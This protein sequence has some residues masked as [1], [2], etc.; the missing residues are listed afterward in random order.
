MLS[1]GASA[2]AAKLRPEVTAAELARKL[3]VTPQAVSGWIKG[4][5]VP[6]PE[7]LSKLEDV[8]GIPMRAWT[9]PVEK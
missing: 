3:G 7:M 6:T 9:E 5:S 8:T 4:R 1:K 2:L